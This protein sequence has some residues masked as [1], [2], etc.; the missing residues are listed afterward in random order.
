MS[1]RSA[2]IQQQRVPSGGELPIPVEIRRENATSVFGTAAPTTGLPRLLR[3]QAYRRPTHDPMRWLILLVADRVESGEHLAR[4]AIAPG[5]QPLVVRH[6]ARQIRA[7]PEGVVSL[8]A[9][10][11]GSVVLARLGVALVRRYCRQAPA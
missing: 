1:E 5:K 3:I 2:P 9:I 4:E 7:H 10:V 6:F 8:A 11:V